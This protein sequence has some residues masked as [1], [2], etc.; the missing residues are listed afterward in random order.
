MPLTKA[1][2]RTRV[3]T[4]IRDTVA[5]YEYSD[6]TLDT[7]LD[8]ALKEVAIAVREVD[9]DYYLSSKIVLAYTDALDVAASGSQGYEFYALPVNMAA[10]RW[11]ERADGD[12]HYKIPVVSARDQEDFR[13]APFW[14]G[15]IEIT[16]SSDAPTAIPSVQAVET[17]SVWGNRFRVIPAPAAAG[18]QYRIVYDKEPEEPEGENE[19]LPVPPAFEEALMKAWGVRP[20]EDDGDPMAAS[21]GVALRG[22]G[23]DPGELKRAMAQHAKR[24]RRT[25]APRAA[26]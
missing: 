8:A 6:S 26:W 2:G 9:P 20:L 4:R 15:T 12:V 18:T 19:M 17:I 10:L 13:L 21:L 23:N 24:T 1:E 5:T 14:A 16:N 3:R 25:I 22:G 7:Y 11:V